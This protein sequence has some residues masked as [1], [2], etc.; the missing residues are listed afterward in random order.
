MTEKVEALEEQAEVARARLKKRFEDFS[1]QYSLVAFKQAGRQLG[2]GRENESITSAIESLTK[3]PASSALLALAAGQLF[4]S[5][6]G[7]R[8][9]TSASRNKVAPNSEKS[10]QLAEQQDFASR[11]SAA[12]WARQ[13][14]ILSSATALAIGIGAGYV[15]INGRKRTSKP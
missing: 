1:D 8:A 9:S 7:N 11:T 6:K 10:E 12:S 13:H 2:H 14:P 4:R 5:Q 3:S 15:L